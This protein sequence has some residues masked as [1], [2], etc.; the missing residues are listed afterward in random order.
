MKR[1]NQIRACK[2]ISSDTTNRQTPAG[3]E[4]PLR[5]GSWLGSRKIFFPGYPLSSVRVVG[6]DMNHLQPVSSMK[7][8]L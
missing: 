3:C 7:E 2:N 4:C 8:N 5:R 1:R 6:K